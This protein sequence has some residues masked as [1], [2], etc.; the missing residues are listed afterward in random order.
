MW[1][2][3]LLYILFFDQSEQDGSIKASDLVVAVGDDPV[4]GPLP[5]QVHHTG[6]GAL[7]HG[8]VDRF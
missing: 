6:G 2:A 1:R 3:P 4:A 5:D 7:H 8:G